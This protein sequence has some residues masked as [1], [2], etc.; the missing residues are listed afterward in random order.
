MSFAR[1]RAVVLA[2]AVLV[3]LA[4]GPPPAQAAPAY[5]FTIVT[6][7]DGVHF[8]AFEQG[9]SANST[10]VR[11]AANSQNV[12]F[13]VKAA[14]YDLSFELCG[15]TVKHVWNGVGNGVKIVVQGCNSFSF[16]PE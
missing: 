14:T 7:A 5:M 16:K 11:V 12:A 8:R 10:G 3:A 4:S 1:I 15:K 6:G 13:L 2:V 9:R